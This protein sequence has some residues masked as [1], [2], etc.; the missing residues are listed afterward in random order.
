[1]AG[2]QEK[3]DLVNLVLGVLIGWETDLSVGGDVKGDV[4][5]V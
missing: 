1:M 2:G 3:G 5:G 4:E